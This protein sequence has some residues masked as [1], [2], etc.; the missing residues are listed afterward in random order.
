MPVTCPGSFFHIS[1]LTYTIWIDFK[2]IFPCTVLNLFSNATLIKKIFYILAI[3][4]LLTSCTGVINIASN[5]DTSYEQSLSK[6]FI[7]GDIL[8][9]DQ[10]F[11]NAYCSTLLSAMTAKGVDTTFIIKGKLGFDTQAGIQKSISNFDPV[12]MIAIKFQSSKLDSTYV[13][14][15]EIAITDVQTKKMIWK[16]VERY[17]NY[18]IS[19]V[20]A[21]GKRGANLTI[22][23]LMKYGLFN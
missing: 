6:F 23:R 22:K 3:S 16:A 8:T 21:T 7:V 5:K 14:S 20:K 1:Q 11:G 12:Q 2:L 13:S 10:K 17:D 4:F 18:A 9:L 15:A 19:A